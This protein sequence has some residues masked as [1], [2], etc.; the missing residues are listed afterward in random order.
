MI[1]PREAVSMG[2]HGMAGFCRPLSRRD[3][4]LTEAAGVADLAQRGKVTR[5]Q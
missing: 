4:E 5:G 3:R 1:L 2:R